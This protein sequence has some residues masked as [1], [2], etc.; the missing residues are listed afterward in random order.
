MKIGAFFFGGVEMDDAGPG[1]PAPMDRRYTNEQCMKATLDYV[2][3][4]IEADRLGYDSF[5]TTEHHFQYEGYEIIPNGL[6][7]SMWIA[8]QTRNIRLGAM[9]NVVPQWNPLRLA[10]DFATLHNLSGGRG[11]LGVGRGTVP[12]EVLH[13]NDKGVSIGSHDNPDQAAADD[14]NREVFE[15]SME[16]IRRSLTQERFS[17][18]GKHFQ[19]PVPGIPDRGTTVQELT[20]IPRPLYPFEI[21][22]AVT[23]P[24]TLGYVPV[25]GHGA[26]FW[27][28]HY[29]FIKRFWD[30]YGQK[31]TEA[32]GVELEAHEKRMLVVSVRIEDTHEKAMETARPGHDEFWKFLGPYGWSRGYMGEGG[33]PA[34]PGLIPSLEESIENKT[35]IVGTPEE[36]AEG[37][38]FYR[39]LLGLEYLTIFPHL[40]GDP[41]KKAD[42]QMARFMTEVVPL[43]S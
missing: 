7:I 28:Q 29:S 40:I 4:A 11:M 27:N 16:I 33:K 22:Q 42:E 2:N 38:Q 31:Y 23:S 39:D 19:I 8:A 14:L 15:E 18:Q 41:Y 24:P 36:V 5:W 3:S 21:W 32:H 37:I 34:K 20:L 26:V 17:F 1:A 25:V 9:F 10:E 12:R 30:T 13:L 6:L 43:V 35:I